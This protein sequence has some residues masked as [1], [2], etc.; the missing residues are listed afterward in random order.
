MFFR[1]KV[2]LYTDGACQGNPGPG[3]WGVVM[4]CD[5]K[6]KEMSGG[7]RDTTNNRMELMAVICGL[8]AL[9]KPCDVAVYSDSKYVIRG[10][11]EW[12]ENWQKNQWKSASKKPVKNVDLWK[13]LAALA[14]HHRVTWHWVKGHAGC[15][16]NERADA[17]ARMGVPAPES[18]T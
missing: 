2:V 6:E 9:K 12:L 7:E 10:M 13:K 8:E 1:K 16:E 4:R 14:M 15:A 17:L 5:G 18:T 11:T 3:G